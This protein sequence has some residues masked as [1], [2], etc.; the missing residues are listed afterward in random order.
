MNQVTGAEPDFPVLNISNRRRRS[1]LFDRV[2][3]S[4]AR[5]WSV[6]NRTVIGQW[7]GSLEED[8]THLK[9]AVQIWDVGGQRIVEVRGSDATRLIQMTTPRD[10][11]P[12]AD[13]RCYYIPMVDAQGRM[14]NDPILVKVEENRFWIC[15]ADGD[16]LM[17]LKGL[18][19]GLGL[20]VDL[21]EP[22]VWTLAIQGPK[23]ED[24]AAAVFGPEVRGIK[25]FRH[26][27]VNVGGKQMILARAGWSKQGGFELHVEGSEHAGPIWDKLMDTGQA[28]EVRA[29]C[30]NLIE[31][32][33]GGLLSFGNDMS[34][35]HTPFEA[36]LDRFCTMDRVTG[37]I[38]QDVLAAQRNPVRQI[39]P[40][41]IK[42]IRVPLVQKLWQV[43]DPS[44]ASAGTVSSA[45]WSPS[46]RTN[47]AI[48]MIS[49]DHWDAGTE[50]QVETPDGM[51]KLIV[52]DRFWGR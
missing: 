31:R 29:G 22:D 36:G 9:R 37:C 16:M 49:R 17:Y 43:T 46:Y 24:L 52:R 26:I 27:R 28:F 30:P 15:M 45:A 10:L 39:R 34:Q 2:R 48:G 20:D 18:A 11:A 21:H 13:D 7:F 3:L 12:M 42:G 35:E 40:V 25:F 41:E 47:V 33:E 19:G 44:G 32:I 1:P 38:A 5:A 51:R 23:S 4:G 14:I 8:Y 50:L 6:Y